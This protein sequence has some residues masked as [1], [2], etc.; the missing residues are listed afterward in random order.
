MNLKDLVIIPK[1][2]LIN[3]LLKVDDLKPILTRMLINEYVQP[4][5][6]LIRGYPVKQNPR[7]YRI[8]NQGSGKLSVLWSADKDLIKSSGEK[9]FFINKKMK[10]ITPSVAQHKVM[11]SMGDNYTL[12]KTFSNLN[13]KIFNEELRKIITIE[14]INYNVEDDTF[15]EPISLKA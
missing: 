4:N 2:K 8:K 7:D 15:S 12:F 3:L 6:K 1:N 11:I 5:Y 13:R 14:I 9:V 10:V